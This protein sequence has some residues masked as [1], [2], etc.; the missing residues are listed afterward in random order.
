MYDDRRGTAAG[1]MRGFG[2]AGGYGLG[3]T[4]NERAP[5]KSII[6]LTT[7]ADRVRFNHDGTI[8][9]VEPYKS[10]QSEYA[11][12]M[13]RN[14]S[15]IR[16]CMVCNVNLCQMCEATFHGVDLHDPAAVLGN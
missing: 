3:L 9:H 11:S 16:C 2:V 12:D 14:R 4:A 6:N 10:N 15:L 8:K 5:L 13:K 1:T 7:S